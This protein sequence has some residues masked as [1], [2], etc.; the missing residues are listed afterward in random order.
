MPCRP[1]RFLSLLTITL[2]LYSTAALADPPLPALGADLK[3]LTV[4]GISSG[5]HMAVQFQVAHSA[6]VRGAG[7]LAAGPFDCAAGSVS[8]ALRNCMAPTSADPPPSLQETRDRVRRLASTQRIDAPDGLNDDR[9]WLFSGGKDTVVAPAVMDALETFYRSLLP[10][11]A[12]RYV[13]DPDAG[14]AMISVADPKALACPATESPFINRCGELDAAGQLLQH[15]L[16]PLQPRNSSPAGR[17]LAFDQ[18]PYIAGRAID[19]SLA[20]RGFVFIPENCAAGGCR[21]HVAF[22]G[23]LQNA[24]TIGPRFVQ[25]AGYNEWAASNRLIVLYPQTVQRYGLALGSWRWVLNPKGCWDWWGYTGAD[26]PTRDGV[27]I[28]AVR[29][30]VDALARPVAAAK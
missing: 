24:E 13:K 26:Y 27:Q 8:R 5:G 11:D 12:V 23:C 28:R 20:E 29:A 7:I 22:H 4:S 6:T 30:M 10:A 9:V 14:H 2:G 19:A 15:L 1:R 21:V 17:L 25:G 16:G 18:R 3:T